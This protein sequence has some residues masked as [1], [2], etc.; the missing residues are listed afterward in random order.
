MKPARKIQYEPDPN[1]FDLVT[2]Q[3]DS[4]GQL[5]KH[6]PYRMFIRDGGEKL[7]ERPLNSGNLWY[8]NNQPAGRVI[9]EFNEQ[10]HIAKKEFKIGAAHIGY[11]KPLSGT[12]KIAAQLAATEQRA[13]EL[14]AELAQIRAEQERKQPKV[15]VLDETPT[16]SKRR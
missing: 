16:L 7:F 15:D 2:H 9:C 6:N 8:E 13:A 11:E 1:K 5:V 10:G 4:Q 14:E 3:W 12:E